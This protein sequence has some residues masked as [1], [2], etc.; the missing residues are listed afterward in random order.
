MNKCS[1][2][3][4]ETTRALHA[5]YQAP[6]TENQIFLSDHATIQS[7]PGAISVNGQNLNQ[8]QSQAELQQAGDYPKKNSSL[9]EFSNHGGR[10]HVESINFRE[11]QANGLNKY[12][13]EQR[14]KSAEENFDKVK[15]KKSKKHRTVERCSTEG[16]SLYSYSFSSHAY[17]YIY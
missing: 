10:G 7:A 16:F 14:N 17:D 15:E 9:K 12:H 11:N 4:E 3:E 2:S 5:A 13:F 6:L 8:G 1:I